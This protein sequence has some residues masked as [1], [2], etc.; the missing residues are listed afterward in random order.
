MFSSPR[1]SGLAIESHDTYPRLILPIVPLYRD[2]CR[3]NRAPQP[4]F[5]YYHTFGRAKTSFRRIR[6][7]A[8]RKTIRPVPLRSYKE[9]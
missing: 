3:A 5:D 2:N 4:L 7:S 8:P 6:L 1:R 9:E